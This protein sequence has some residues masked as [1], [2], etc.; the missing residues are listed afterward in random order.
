MVG[1]PYG[2]TKATC[3]AL[4]R[5]HRPHPSSSTPNPPFRFR[6]HSSRQLRSSSRLLLAQRRRDFTVSNVCVQERQTNASMADLGVP[7]RPSP[8]NAPSNGG[9]LSRFYLTP[10]G[11]IRQVRLRRPRVE[12]CAE[13]GQRI[14][15]G[16]EHG[17]D[18][19]RCTEA[20]CRGDDEAADLGICLD[21]EI[22]GSYLGEADATS[23]RQSASSDG[24]MRLGPRSGYSSGAPD[25][26]IQTVRKPNFVAPATSQRLDD[27]KETT[28][29]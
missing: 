13:P 25:R 10:A 16:D 12:P 11:R 4:K 19:G 22:E 3:L 26:L 5:A 24:R 27:W 6:P 23:R 18:S 28:S 14:G 21:L 15:A 20:V 1:A 8:A 7:L 9:R 2:P 17:R 29:G